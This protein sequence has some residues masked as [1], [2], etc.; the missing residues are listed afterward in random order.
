MILLVPWGPPG[1]GVRHGA[2]PENPAPMLRGPRGYLGTEVLGGRLTL[3]LGRRCEA[4][5]G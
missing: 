5:P 4:G 3:E 1:N 2:F